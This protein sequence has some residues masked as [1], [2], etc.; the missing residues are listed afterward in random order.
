MNHAEILVSAVECRFFTL[1]VPIPPYCL[2]VATLGPKLFLPETPTKK[3]HDAASLFVLPTVHPTTPMPLYLIHRRKSSLSLPQTHHVVCV[4]PCLPHVMA[5]LQSLI[6]HQSKI[7][8]QCILR[9]TTQAQQKPRNR[10]SRTVSGFASD[11]RHLP[12][13]P[14]TYHSTG[15]SNWCKFC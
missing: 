4:L 3:A 5:R 11:A 14:C 12:F 6:H 13:C 2:P 15:S 1:C 9:G 10:Q 7:T 8:H